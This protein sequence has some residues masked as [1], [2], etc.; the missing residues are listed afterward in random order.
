M[1]ASDEAVLVGGRPHRCRVFTWE[2]P[3]HPKV[4]FIGPCTDDP[5]RR[6]F[7]PEPFL[8]LL[9]AGKKSALT[10]Q[11]RAAAERSLAAFFER[12]FE[13]GYEAL[14]AFHPGGKGVPPRDEFRLMKALFRNRT[15][16]AVAVRR[17]LAS[18]SEL[19]RYTSGGPP[20][21]VV[22]G[23]E[24]DPG[25]AHAS[26]TFAQNAAACIASALRAVGHERESDV[27]LPAAV[28]RYHQNAA[29]DA[30]A[31]VQARLKVVP[32]VE[33]IERLEGRSTFDGFAT[34]GLL[35]G[36]PWEADR[37]VNAVGGGLL[38]GDGPLAGDVLR[39]RTSP[40]AAT[41]A[42]RLSAAAKKP[43]AVFDRWLEVERRKGLTRL[44]GA[45]FPGLAPDGELRD[46]LR[47]DYRVLL[48]RAHQLMARC[49]GAWAWRA[50]IDFELHSPA[51]RP[52]AWEGWLFRQ[53]N[54]PNLALAGLPVVFLSG[55][56]VPWVWDVFRGVWAEG[57]GALD[58]F[59][60][61][62]DRLLA[63]EPVTTEAAP[64][65]PADLRGLDGTLYDAVT[66]ALGV[67][68]TVAAEVRVADRELKRRRAAMTGAV[69][70]EGGEAERG[71]SH[72]RPPAPVA[73]RCRLP[74]PHVPPGARVYDGDLTCRQCGRGYELVDNYE[75]EDDG[76]L[77]AQV[78]CDCGPV[79][80]FC[81]E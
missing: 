10:P 39:S 38:A 47:A 7:L 12:A 30:A 63:N 49:Y 81:T 79:W 6:L 58:A 71:G 66:A 20:K 46:A 61:A 78:R 2:R 45:N 27:S 70:T 74:I 33:P 44:L 4:R 65:E 55:G 31:D 69:R 8:K 25:A 60:H 50:W 13:V 17:R 32:H 73:S 16:G 36:T 72:P 3:G 34:V 57:A 54:L 68:A 21:V 18:A 41:M 43:A 24:A 23:L 5:H 64:R 42:A 9:G 37:A 14:L 52:A 1:I 29:F 75:A 80:F 26:R 51:G 53:Q 62:A 56:Q 67:Y 22:P 35:R 59:A 28:K 77:L 40:Y 76:T 19:V 11:A 48:W 15:M